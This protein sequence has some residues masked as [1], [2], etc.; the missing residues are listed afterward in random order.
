MDTLL[1]E[2]LKPNNLDES[3][4]EHF[5]A[6]EYGAQQLVAVAGLTGKLVTSSEA[7]KLYRAEHTEVACSMIMLSASNYLPS[8]E[9]SNPAV[10]A[11]YTN[12]MSVY[13]EP[14]QVQVSYVKFNVTNYWAETVKSISNLDAMVDMQ[15]KN[16]GTN[17]FGHT[18]TPEE[19]RAAIKDFLIRTNALRLARQ[20]AGKFA[21]ELDNLLPKKPE[22][23]ETLA[24][25]KGLS[26][27]TT[28][29]F[30]EVQGP[31]DL[32]VYYNFAPTAFKLT[33]EE[34][35][36]G[37]VMAHD[38]VYVLGFKKLTPSEIPPFNTISNKV[39]ADFR[40]TQGA[41]A[42]QGVATNVY[43]VLTNGLAQGKSFAVLVA[44]LG[45]KTE[46]IPPFSLSTTKLPESLEDRISMNALR[47]AG[48]G[49]EVGSVSRPARG[50]HGIFMLYIEKKLPVDEAKLK[51]ELPGFLA[52]LRQVRENDAFN[53]WCFSQIRQ[54]PGF[55]ATLQ[56]IS[57]QQTA[58]SGTAA[59]RTR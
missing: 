13:R 2:V 24:K 6:H 48:F 15:V 38:G 28:E 46:S 44:Q 37:S 33:P 36:S 34:P 20:D 55:A 51:S 5:L 53:Q 21:D 3:D 9:V 39:L 19:S 43:S 57:Q 27:Q 14:A 26:L 47:Q 58:R 4:F 30:D 54:D 7:E 11:F 22:N 31:K 16:A 50:E 56:Q 49:T 45:L 59:P 32:D 8:V 17:L 18:K 40:L 10:L 52:Y 42:A 35:F 12:R 23:I 1:N 25:Q 41:F 29:P